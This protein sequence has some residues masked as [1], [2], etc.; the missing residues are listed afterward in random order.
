MKLIRLILI[1][2]F[3]IK[4]NSINLKNFLLKKIEK[5]V[6]KFKLILNFYY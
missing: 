6:L 1:E 3:Y 5:Q 4:N 2:K